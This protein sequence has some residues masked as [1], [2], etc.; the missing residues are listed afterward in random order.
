[1][2]TITS[3]QNGNW[4]DTSTW[5]GGVVPST[6]DKARILNNHIVTING[7]VDVGDGSNQGLE[8]GQGTLK[9]NRS[10]DITL[11][12]TGNLYADD[13]GV[14]DM[15]TPEDPCLGN[16]EIQLNKTGIDNYGVYFQRNCEMYIHGKIR[17]TNSDVNA[18]NGS[19]LSVDDTTGWEVGDEIVVASIANR[20]QPHQTTISAISGNNV[21]LSSLPSWTI[22]PECPI[23][24]K[25]KN[26][27]FT[28]HPSAPTNRTVMRI[29]NLLSNAMFDVRH[30]RIHNLGSAGT[31]SNVNNVFQGALNLHGAGR[32]TSYVF[33][34][35]SITSDFGGPRGIDLNS[36][37]D[38]TG[39]YQ[40][41]LIC[42][43]VTN[44]Y[45]LRTRSG[46]TLDFKDMVVYDGVQIQSSWSQGSSGVSFTRCKFLHRR[47]SVGIT[48]TGISMTFQDCLFACSSE[49]FAPL[50]A[51]D[52]G[53]LTLNNCEIG[54]TD[55][56]WNI[57][58][59]R[60]ID[61][62]GSGYNCNVNAADNTYG[63]SS[64]FNV[65]DF[66]GSSSILQ[67]STSS[68]VDD[69]NYNQTGLNRV[70][71]T[72]GIKTQK[73]DVKLLGGNA[74]EFKTNENT[75]PL[76]QTYRALIPSGVTCTVAGYYRKENGYTG[77]NP[78]IK[79]TSESG[80]NQSEELTGGS[81]QWHMFEID[82]T[83]N[84]GSDEFISIE[85]SASS[86]T[87]EL[88]YLDS[89]FLYSYGYTNIPSMTPAVTVN[90][91]LLL[92]SILENSL[93][94]QDESTASSHTGI[95][96]TR[97]VT[98]IT[99][100]GKQFSIT[101]EGN[102][103]VNPNLTMEDIQHYLYYN[104]NRAQSFGGLNSGFE[105]NDIFPLGRTE[106]VEFDS[107][108]V[109]VVDE[110]EN[111]FRGVTRMQSN[112]GSYY[113]SPVLRQLT[114]SGLITNSRV[115]VYNV[116][117]DTELYNQTY[118][119]DLNIEYEEGVGISSG[120]TIRFRITYANGTNYKEPIEIN[121]IASAGGVS[122]LVS[123]QDWTPV[124]ALGIDGS[125][126]TEY[127]TDFVNIQIDINDLDNRT[128]KKR[129][130]AWYAYVLY[131]S[132]QALNDFFGGL[133][134]EDEVNY[135]VNTDIV[136][137]QLENIKSEPLIFTDS[138]TRL[139]S[140]D[141][142][143]LLATTGGSIFM[144]SGKVFIDNIEV[145]TT[146]S[147]LSKATLNRTK[148]DTSTNTLIVYEGDGTTVAFEYDLKDNL[149]NSSS[150]NVYERVP[151]E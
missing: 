132:S 130:V 145:D 60:G 110:N 91:S 127:S 98:P 77:T 36:Y 73:T 119:E 69:I 2:A 38:S 148:M 40:N 88:S 113:V 57:D 15:G 105:W 42:L 78:T 101:I 20:D 79:V 129:L 143:S 54:K 63:M 28:Q 53:L 17:T 41:F 90:S 3:A 80:I 117:T 146:L 13:L 24:N 1:M 11:Q 48:I 102:L 100:N 27:L 75:N 5:Q 149:G 81:N 32:N 139:Y 65:I 62:S 29:Q 10:N 52:V 74:I 94:T 49:D 83:Q 14:L 67:N 120:D 12:V 122:I 150:T 44:S 56:N 26:I 103:S 76:T 133:T 96:I 107:E 111:F 151:K 64:G 7:D 118:L 125:T 45:L 147:N 99:W 123:Q 31:P 141:G 72:T 46:S 121:A 6:G 39:T 144:D 22:Y 116:T 18:V 25:T 82:V 95:T 21:T 55:G 128:T 135:K 93:V 51:T 37:R 59:T 136:S 84:T 70:A 87:D 104:F 109:R 86:S 68:Y 58:Y 134:I 66:T 71:R 124:N 137:L 142:S 61:S 140:S 43:S 8:I 85:Y 131:S 126:I 9:F 34:D 106:T 92:G 23:G 50:Q 4:E 16:I 19:I 30:F 33:S 108:G 114:T 115:Q 47:S 138:D 112:D 35:I 89:L 97:H